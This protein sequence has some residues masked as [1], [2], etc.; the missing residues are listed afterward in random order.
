MG[1]SC[2]SG[3]CVCLNVNET[4]CADG[5]VD[6][7]TTPTDCGSCG[8]ACEIGGVCKTG[9]CGCTGN[10]MCGGPPTCTQTM[11]P[12]DPAN[13]GACG[14]ICDPTEFCTDG[15]CVCRFPYKLCG[16]TCVDITS[17]P[18][19]CGACGTACPMNQLCLSPGIGMP[20]KCVKPMGAA[21]CPSSYTACGARCVLTSF[22]NGDPADCGSCNNTCQ[23]DEVCTMA[24]ACAKYFASPSCNTCPCAAC[25]V[26]HTCC[27]MGGVP[28]CVLGTTCGF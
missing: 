13:C 9:M 26:G 25:G 18:A 5:C 17:D 10:L 12:G 6:L 14:K 22:M 11:G 2:V 28:L 3:K 27:M 23:R 8:H 20:G 1:V 24:G 19:N 7:E 15:A 21:T 4:A 16:G